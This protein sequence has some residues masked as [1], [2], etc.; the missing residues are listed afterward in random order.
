[1]FIVHGERFF[2]HD[3]DSASGAD[4]H[5][6]LM[7][8]GAG[9]GRDGLRLCLFEHPFERREHDRRVELEL[10]DV[11]RGDFR[12]RLG[13]ADDLDVRAVQSATQE[14]ADVAVFESDN[15]EAER[16]RVG[17]EE[18]GTPISL[19]SNRYDDFAD[20]LVGLHVA[21]GVDNLDEREG[22]VD[23]R[24]S[25]CLKTYCFPSSNAFGLLTTSNSV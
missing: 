13:D 5:H 11:A 12:V 8:E 6:S 21:M 19:S 16:G 18:R 3:V 22:S 24:A 17:G 14:A 15:A 9:H 7:V 20:L 10:L 25:S 4:L 23:A 1:M 2:H